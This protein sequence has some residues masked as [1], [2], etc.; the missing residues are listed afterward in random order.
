[1]TCAVALVMVIYRRFPDTPGA[2]P[3]VLSSLL[4]LPIA[5]LLGDPWA[6][7]PGK[8]GILAGFGLV[9]AVAQVALAEGAKRL[10]PSEAGLLSSLEA[11]L[12][13]GL[14]WL[15]LFE[16]PPSQTVLGG[17]VV[18]VAVVSTQVGARER[19]AGSDPPP[20]P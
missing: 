2:G 3:V 10:P 15:I 16:A 8:V 13:P 1:M 18:L 4:L 20:V 12:A 14:A 11:A 7:A 6:V 9:F 19:V 5:L 17:A